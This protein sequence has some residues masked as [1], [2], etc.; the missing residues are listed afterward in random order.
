MNSPDDRNANLEANLMEARQRIEAIRANMEADRAKL[1]SLNAES[2]AVD[3][4]IAQLKERVMNTKRAM[5]LAKAMRKVHQT[6]EERYKER[7][8]QTVNSATISIEAPSTI[9]TATEDEKHQQ[10]AQTD[11]EEVKVEEQHD[12][13][14]D[15]SFEWVLV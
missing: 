12:T 14:E 10:K 2:D 6:E 1:K 13:E 11:E 9:S 15:L 4:S 5:L 3:V 7:Q 8:L